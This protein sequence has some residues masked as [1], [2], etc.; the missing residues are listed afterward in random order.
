MKGFC[1]TL[2]FLL[3]LIFSIEGQTI[4]YE[5]HSG[6]GYAFSEE[7]LTVYMDI[8]SLLTSIKQE[9]KNHDNNPD[10]WDIFDE[11]YNSVIIASDLFYAGYMF[12]TT[13]VV[14]FP[15]MFTISPDK[16]KGVAK[17]E[18]NDNND[19]GHSKLV[20]V[21]IYHFGESDCRNIVF[22]DSFAVFPSDDMDITRKDK[23]TS[24]R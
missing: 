19:L 22:R 15:E 23:E 5:Y 14:W 13:D 10:D 2:F 3:C 9:I 18:Y 24:I 11:L 6:T 8:D 21:T 16:E 1:I 7:L 12:H 17:F 20:K 4:R